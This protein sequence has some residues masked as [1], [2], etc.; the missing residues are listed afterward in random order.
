VA[1][2]GHFATFKSWNSRPESCHLER[3]DAYSGISALVSQNW[4]C[5]SSP[6]ADIPSITQK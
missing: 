4:T 5:P 2:F 3:D 1:E 6:A